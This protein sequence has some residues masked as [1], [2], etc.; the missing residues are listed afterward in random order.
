M[1]PIKA[2]IFGV[3]D[4]FRTLKP[5]YDR[6]VEKGNLEIV[7]YALLKGNNVIFTKNLQ[8]EPLQDISFQKIII[9]AQSDF[10]PIFKAAKSLLRTLKGGGYNFK[11]DIIDGRIF[12]I[13]GFDFI[14][15]CFEGIVYAKNLSPIFHEATSSIP[16]K[17][18]DCGNY[19][20]LLGAKSYMGKS[21]IECQNF[22]VIRVG[23]FSA[24][25]WDT[26]FE[27]NLNY[28][29][30][31]RNVASYGLMRFEWEISK[32]F[33]P[34]YDSQYSSIIIGSDVWIGRGCRFKVSN[35]DKPLVIGNGAVLAADSVVVKDV[36]PYAIVGGNPAKF[37][38]WRFSKDIIEA[39]ERIAW[40]NWD[41]E[42]I[43]D[44]FYLFNDPEKFVNKFDIKNLNSR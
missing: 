11:Q 44:N 8:G 35:L 39:L 34:N 17:I 26:L 28:D 15:F 19:K 2:L 37:I 16:A 22:G 27:L 7:G 23:N 36:P 31:H 14:K 24:I 4:L 21:I 1:V 40:W 5:F 29:H 38:K 32:D 41:L 42:K 3:D 13:P 10:I 30:N 12:Q 25:G 33:Y 9:S 43:H 18:Y 20:V 6:E